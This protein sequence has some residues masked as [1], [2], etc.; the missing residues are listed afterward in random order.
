MVLTLR[1]WDVF[2]LVLTHVLCIVCPSVHQ[3]GSQNLFGWILVVQNVIQI[4]DI[5]HFRRHSQEHRLVPT[6]MQVPL[7]NHEGS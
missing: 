4:M 5:L 3:H 6:I 7:Q 2:Q 1:K